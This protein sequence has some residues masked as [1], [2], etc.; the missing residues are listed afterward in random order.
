MRTFANALIRRARREDGGMTA[1]GL[2]TMMVFFGFGGLALDVGNAY[3]VRTQ[4]Q[5]AADATAHAALYHREYLTAANAKVAALDVA[6]TA[7]PTSHYGE[8]IK[9]TDIDFGYWDA[10]AQ[11]FTVDNNS[12][13]A[14]RVRSSRAKDRGNGVLTY[15]LGFVGI[16]RWDVRRDAVFETYLPTC[17]REG[18][19]AQNEVDLQ[20]NNGYTNG[21]CIHSNLHVEINLNNFFADNTVVSMPDKQQ[22]VLP[23]SGFESNEGLEAALRDGAYRIRILNV[24]GSIIADLGDPNSDVMP[25]YITSDTVIG[26]TSRQVAQEDLTPGS[27]HTLSCSG[28]QTMKFGNG[29][30]VNNIVIVTNCKVQFGAGVVLDNAIVATTNVDVKSIDGPSGVQI[31]RD[32]NCAPDGGS[33]LLTM[34][35]VSF[36]AQLQVFGGQI[37]AQDNIE[38]AAEADGIEGASFISGNVISGTSNMTMGFCGSGMERNFERAYFRLAA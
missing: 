16:S 26:M 13:D 31:G 20:S 6:H 32:D 27:V 12:K 34:G 19:V 1:Y 5:V 21:F 18:F 35:G 23:E 7:L 22:V 2:I 17:F 37:I 15:M 14:V 4:V 29:V 28:G 10:V 11:T 38:F 8:V 24:L 36:P 3:R 33:Q 9:T 30:L 25:D